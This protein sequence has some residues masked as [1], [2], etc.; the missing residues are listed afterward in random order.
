MAL[1]IFAV[2]FRN[3]MVQLKRKTSVKKFVIIAIT[4][5]GKHYK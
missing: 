1:Y 4:D 3:N 2:S 5:L